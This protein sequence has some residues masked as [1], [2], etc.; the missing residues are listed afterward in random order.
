LL[1]STKQIVKRAGT[2]S[3]GHNTQFNCGN[4][5]VFETCSHVAQTGFKLV[6]LQMSLS[7]QSFCLLSAGIIGTIQL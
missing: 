3:I 2:S 5:S 1:G 7:F 4:I 6:E